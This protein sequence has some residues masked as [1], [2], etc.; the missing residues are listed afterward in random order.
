[1]TSAISLFHPLIQKW[2]LQNFEQPTDIQNQSWP[3]I[4]SKEHVLITAPTG[5]GKTLTAFLW[6]INQLVTENRTTEQTS[7]LYVS[8]LKAL[9][10]DI[11]R[12][13]NQPLSAIK[14]VFEK[15]GQEFP[16][17]RVSTRSGDTSQSD[18]RRMLRHPPE[19]LITTPESFNLLLSSQSGRTILTTLSTVIL[20]E[21]HAVVGDK[22]GTHL[23]TAV[24]RLV[25]LSGEFQRIA[26]SATVK[27]LEVVADFTGGFELA[28]GK[29]APDYKP[30]KV[31]IVQSDT[32]KE[33]DIKVKFPENEIR[34]DIEDS[35]W[36]T[37]A[38]EFTGIIRK[39]RST[40]L[41]ANSRKLSEKLTYLINNAAKQQLAYS[42]HGSL[43]KQIR[44]E[45]EQKL[46]NGELKAIVATSSLEMGIDIG[47]LDEV[48]LIQSPPS[49]SSAI[50]RVGRA[51]H[52]V[53]EISRGTIFPSHAQD[54]I[55]SAVLAEAITAQNIEE[56]KPIRC[57][58]D[59]LAQV[60]I[61][62]IGVETWDIDEL[63][64][65]VK[66]SYPYRQLSKEQFDIV[67]NM[68]AGRYADSRIRELKPRISIDRLDNTVTGKKGSL[69]AVYMSGGT[70]PD[71][72]Y[73]Q[74]RHQ[75]TGARIGELDE[76]YVWE[77]QIGQVAT[78][79]TQNWKIQRITHNDVFATPV[80]ANIMDTPF[81]KSEEY[82]RDFHLSQ[83][84]STFLEQANDRLQEPGYEEELK[85]KYHMNSVA[86]R[87][88]I[89]FLS[90]Q[91]DET[92]SDLPH[93]HHILFEFVKSGPDGAPGTQLVIHTLWGG[94]LNRPFAMALDAAWE[95]KYEERL[96][97]FPGNDCVIL[98]LAHQMQPEAIL[99]MVTGASV[100]TLLRKRLEDSG[101]FGARF[102]ECA[103]RALL[104]TRNKISER[105]P[106]WMTRLRSQKLL[107]GVLHYDDFPILLETWRTCL[108]DEF[109]LANLQLMLSE[110]ESGAITWSITNT[111]GPS[112]FAT[113]MTWNQINK[114][115][116]QLDQPASSPSSLSGNL[117]RDVVFTPDLRPAISPEIIERFELKR[118]RLYPGYSP[119]T[120]RDLV[121]WVKER[122]ALP[123]SEWIRLKEAITR[124]NPNDGDE[125]IKAALEKLVEIKP[126]KTKSSF[127]ISLELLPK[128][129]DGFYRPGYYL[130]S[131]QVD[132]RKPAQV[133]PEPQSD[134]N[135]RSFEIDFNLLGEWLQ[136]YGPRP[137]G[138]VSAIFGINPEETELALSSLID[139]QS[140]VS[141]TLVLDGN[142]GDICDSENFEILL[143]MSRSD[144]IPQFEALG[145][146]NLAPFL[147]V[148]QGVAKPADSI[149]GLFQRLEQLTCFPQPAEAWEAETF[150][151]RLKPYQTV[152]LDSII[153]EGDLRWLG[154]G[155]QKIAFSFET[156]LDL[157]KGGTGESVDSESSKTEVKEPGK[158]EQIISSSDARYDFG[159][160][161]QL[162]GT[163]P[164]N[165]AAQTWDL[166]WKGKLTNDTY[167]SLRKG[168]EN[169]FKL[170][171]ITDNIPL[172]SR[173]GRRSTGRGGF[174]KWKGSLPF[175]GNWFRLKTPEPAQDLLENEELKKDRVRLLLERYGILFRELLQKEIPSFRWSS[176]FRSLR[177]M[178]LSGEV[179]AGYFFKSIPGP[180]FISQQAFRI[181]QSQLPKD[182]IYWM[183]ATD[184]A[185][186]CGIAI[187]ELKGRFP[188]RL[189]GNHL[190]F[191]GADP[192]LIS[193][194]NGKSLT[195]TMD[196]NDDH[197]Q[198]IYAPLKNLLYRQFNP[199]KQV[200]V[201]K[202]NG[203]DAAFS[204]YLNS[205]KTSF[206]VLVEFKKVTLYRKL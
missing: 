24:D 157:I 21:I 119:Q 46:K 204:P 107:E 202:I 90:R 62:M 151:A 33:Y 179:L 159:T 166:V 14:T 193:K 49:V 64:C 28:G 194:R 180:Q 137:P 189:A 162:S 78:L 167:S 160:L 95:E 19:I 2:F 83:G 101:F 82:G 3:K 60:L 40:L 17:I 203:E 152:W 140:V 55:S 174:A 195:I 185:S 72:G 118:Q 177:L 91:K 143:R 92:L 18:R 205:L 105:M 87:E 133:E 27:P 42:H 115:M 6:A 68:L 169:R 88:L 199:L 163:S 59:V 1:M 134:S 132:S 104:I 11:L 63:L 23:I 172:K 98:Q 102:R 22:R 161:V 50:Q 190:V 85:Q 181:L 32:R 145:I 45:V 127:I 184:P 30:R 36:E 164:K 99:S 170:D 182:A 112:P 48:V 141:G 120:A 117:L 74:L 8:P 146:E 150:P 178:E 31:S 175:A 10:N 128:I 44:E 75:E 114:Y 198:E 201:E 71:R 187:D 110:L 100:E 200:V 125:V 153:Q 129:R 4:A 54:F 131:V 135:G 124:D 56:I 142:A 147:A 89:R 197:L 69:L 173:Q 39:N 43:S 86:A 53:G 130:S 13:L 73:F 93:R 121:D 156:D 113:G 66:T 79:G 149:E 70:I 206:E 80:G 111:S 176:I 139:A 47:D 154:C 168:I 186:L 41:F 96:E 15:A 165:L 65:W 20:D 7:V 123:K 138:F 108:Q 37:L 103:G 183:N 116:Y 52:H 38:E 196:V 57:P 35:L 109:D 148:I 25:R 58:L 191:K 51:G 94:K 77:A 12:N 106:L 5:S 29:Q 97:V 192:V 81:W 16:L 84:I 136:F 76:E 126:A 155:K 122:I 34:K 144:A 188:K 61:S 158:L 9:N 67:L 26:L 171:I